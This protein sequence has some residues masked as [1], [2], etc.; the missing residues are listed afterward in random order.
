MPHN[1]DRK[2]YE[3]PK[4]IKKLVIERSNRM[5]EWPQGCLERGR[6][7]DHITSIKI[8]RLLNGGIPDPSIKS[9]ENAQYLCDWHNK[10]KTFIENWMTLQLE[11][12]IA[13]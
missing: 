12:Q 8:S 5:C 7:I 2:G 6:F 11:K 4:R 3:F 1:P 9:E 13:S 10:A